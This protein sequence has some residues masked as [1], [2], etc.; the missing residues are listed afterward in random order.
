MLLCCRPRQCPLGCTWT[1]GGCGHSP[2]TLGFTLGHGV[3]AS[4]RLQEVRVGIG[5]S[6]EEFVVMQAPST[7]YHF[8]SFQLTFFVIDKGMYLQPLVTG[9][10]GQNIFPSP[11]TTLKGTV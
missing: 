9:A 11:Q 4:Q 2:G 5:M 3:H 10:F 1:S 6:L 8:K 7:C